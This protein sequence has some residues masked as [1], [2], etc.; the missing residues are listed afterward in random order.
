LAEAPK[1]E[2]IPRD[3]KEHAGLYLDAAALL[4]RRTGEM[5]LAL[6]TPTE[7]QAFSAEPFSLADLEADAARIGDQVARTL[8]ALKRG[9]TGLPDE[10]TTEAAA[11]LLARR[12]ELF[13]RAASIT[14]PLSGAAAEET[15]PGI[16]AQSGLRTRIHGDYHLG[17][18]L[19]A[20]GD[21]VI[22]DFEGEPAR[23]LTERRAKQSPLRDVAGMLLLWTT[24]PNGIRGPSDHWSCG[25]N[26]GKTLYVRSSWQL[27]GPP[28]RRTRFSLHSP[29]R[30]IVC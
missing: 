3:A 7:N 22:L 10:Y 12:R 20:R 9:F 15:E 26:F 18:V 1:P 30:P 23:P 29:C 14:Q 27:G 17:Q 5:H 11:L 21:Y 13:G 25:R 2:L 28:W 19:R 8:D 24:L 4:G 6:A 16:Q